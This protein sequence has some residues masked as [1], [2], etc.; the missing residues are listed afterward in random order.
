M[1]RISAEGFV[2]LSENEIEQIQGGDST[3]LVDIVKRWLIELSKIVK[4]K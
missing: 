4:N 1:D 3:N 2:E